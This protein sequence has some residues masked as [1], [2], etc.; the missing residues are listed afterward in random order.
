MSNSRVCVCC[1]VL[2]AMCG[3]MAVGEKMLSIESKV[4]FQSPLFWWNAVGEGWRVDTIQFRLFSFIA[5]EVS[6]QVVRFFFFLSVL[7]R[8]GQKSCSRAAMCTRDDTGHRKRNRGNC[9]RFP[10]PNPIFFFFLLLAFPPNFVGLR[11][12]VKKGFL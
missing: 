10:P 7:F 1:V 4:L 3:F 5:R 2:S 12:S 9:Q 8:I 6:G 11:S